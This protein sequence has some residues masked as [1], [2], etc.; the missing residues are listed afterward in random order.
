MNELDA[1][2]LKAKAAFEEPTVEETTVEQH[3]PTHKSVLNLASID[4]SEPNSETS[5]LAPED[6]MTLT[7]SEEIKP[8]RTPRK[9][10]EDEKR[11]VGRIAWVVWKTYFKVCPCLGTLH[12]IAADIQEGS[13]RPG[14]V[15]FV[16][17][18]SGHCHVRSCV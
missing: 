2:E 12:V 10:I 1:E 11:A 17:L 13:W 4:S 14:L 6:E 16:H 9:L 5:S 3:K 8:V 18:H 15:D 7:N